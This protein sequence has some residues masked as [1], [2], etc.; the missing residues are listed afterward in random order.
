MKKK[1]YTTITPHTQVLH[2]IFM[3]ATDFDEDGDDSQLAMIANVLTNHYYIVHNQP[4]LS[5]YDDIKLIPLYIYIAVQ[6]V[7]AK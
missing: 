5:Y 6:Y 2:N 7:I 3:V 1:F 4:K